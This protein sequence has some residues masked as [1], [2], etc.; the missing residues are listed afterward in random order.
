[1]EELQS[2]L[3]YYNL[4]H[5]DDMDVAPW[6][7]QYCE[8]EFPRYWQ[9]VYSILEKFDRK[10]VSNV[11]FGNYKTHDVVEDGDIVYVGNMNTSGDWYIKKVVTDIL[12]DISIRYTNN[13]ASSVNYDYT[14]AFINKTELNY[15]PLSGL[16]VI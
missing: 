5:L 16:G 11:I 7:K 2:L 10:I 12:G 15:V 6:S 1:M 9:V 14:S 8:D 4:S 13:Y 3:R